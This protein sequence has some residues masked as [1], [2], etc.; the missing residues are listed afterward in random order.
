MVELSSN[1]HDPLARSLNVSAVNAV[2]QVMCSSCKKM[3]IVGILFM[4]HEC[5]NYNLCM[6]CE[7][8]LDHS[9]GHAMLIFKKP[10]Q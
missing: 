7:E 8:D 10:Q 6:N 3:P 5:P 1:L 2:H 4:C 9:A